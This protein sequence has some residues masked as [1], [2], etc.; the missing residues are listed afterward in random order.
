[1]D[2]VKGMGWPW[3]A[4]AEAV[5]ARQDAAQFA[6]LV[7]GDKSAS[8]TDRGKAALELEAALSRENSTRDELAA[9]FLLMLRA[10]IDKRP[11]ALRVLVESFAAEVKMRALMNWLVTTKPG[12]MSHAMQA[13]GRMSQ[14]ESAL[15]Q[16]EQRIGQ[17]EWALAQLENRTEGVDCV[18]R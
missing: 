13:D 10:A 12:G 8:V 3:D 7:L 6:E 4:L 15:A 5:Y 1:M 11:D 16:A 9:V 2:A 17:L 14:L 18:S